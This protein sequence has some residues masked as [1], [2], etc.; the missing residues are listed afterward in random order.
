MWSLNFII[1]PLDTFEIVGLTIKS[2]KNTPIAESKIK[3]VFYLQL[4]EFQEKQFE[5]TES[6][7][8]SV[9]RYLLNFLSWTTCQDCVTLLWLSLATV[10]YRDNMW[11]IVLFL[12][13]PGL[14]GCKTSRAEAAPI[15]SLSTTQHHLRSH[16]SE[17]FM[18]IFYSRKMRCAYHW[19]SNDWLKKITFFNE[20]KREQNAKR[21]SNPRITTTRALCSHNSEDSTTTDT[22][23]TPLSWRTHWKLSSS[24]TC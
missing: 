12:G 23:T 6:P 8:P 9:W 4:A 13:L 20:I 16:Y 18:Q 10:A 14:L 19:Y 7:W 22:I 1:L 5:S 21:L 3:V 11:C 15:C 24:F 2:D 17:Y